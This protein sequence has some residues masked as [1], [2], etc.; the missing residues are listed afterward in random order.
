MIAKEILKLKCGDVIEV[1]FGVAT[2]TTPLEKYLV[3]YAGKVDNT[4]AIK[5]VHGEVIGRFMEVDPSVWIFP[6][7]IRRKI[8]CI[9]VSFLDSYLRQ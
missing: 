3:L 8:G 9:T 7:Q 2:T 4:N 6:E 5:A 1:V